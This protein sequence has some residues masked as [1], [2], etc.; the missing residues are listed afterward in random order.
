MTTATSVEQLASSQ[1]DRARHVLGRAFH[2]YPLMQYAM[3]DAA[4]RLRG[5][6]A[7]YGAILSDCLRH[8][9]VY[10]ADNI[11]AV[12][13]WLPPGTGVPGFVRQ[14]QAG[15]L[16][17]P[18][19]FGLRGTQRL[20]AYDKIAQRLHHEYAPEPHWYLASLGV[21]P[22]RQRQGLGSRLLE[23]HLAQADRD[24][25]AC[26]LDTHRESNVRLYERHGFHVTWQG[27]APGHP[28]TIWSMRRDA[29]GAVAAG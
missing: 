25:H 24:G 8:G 11:A 18:L 17:L 28:V 13:C 26:Y 6:T 7:L 29:S 14:L 22:D 15:I 9:A 21:E 2:D 16:K 1:Y 19:G 4:R 27:T 20:L 12:A 3:P 5:T 10:G 23:P